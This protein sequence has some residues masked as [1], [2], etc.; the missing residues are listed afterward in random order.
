ML[1]PY[2][3]RAS[4]HVSFIASLII[5]AIVSSAL[6]FGGIAAAQEVVTPPAPGDG[7]GSAILGWVFKGAL[8]L[9]ILAGGWAAVKLTALIDA[10]TKQTGLSS[11]QSL[12]YS[13]INTVWLKAQATGSKLI[14]KEKPLLD[15]ILSDGVVTAEEFQVFKAALVTDL[16]EIAVQE[17]PILGN[18]LG[19]A[20]PANSIIEGFASKAAH[21][22][23]SGQ[24]AAPTTAADKPAS[25]S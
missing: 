8:T 25:P 9:A 2:F 7:G 20:G 4:R 12:I 1:N 22:L 17:I 23:I 10:K 11:T 16:R 3:V 6:F 13:T 14:A 15:K 24:T 19:G 18:L 5:F 21:A